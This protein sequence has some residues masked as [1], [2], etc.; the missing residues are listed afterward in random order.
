MARIFA[1]FGINSQTL[2]GFEMTVAE[3]GGAAAARRRAA[4]SHLR[5]LYGPLPSPVTVA[6][7]GCSRRCEAQ[8]GRFSLSAFDCPPIK[9]VADRG[10]VCVTAFASWL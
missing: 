2:R 7:V 6:E 9:A 8:G 4:H 10:R 5:R 3:V 1:N